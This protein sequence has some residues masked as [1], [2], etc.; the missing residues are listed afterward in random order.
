MIKWWKNRCRNVDSGNEADS[1]LRDDPKVSFN[2]EPIIAYLNDPDYNNSALNGNEWVLNE[3]TNFD[4]SL[5]CDDV[6]GLVDMSPLH[7]P[8]P[9]SMTCMHIEKNDGSVFVVP[10]SK[11]DQSPIIFGKV[12]YWITTANDSNEN[13]ELP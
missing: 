3:K 6:N 12:Q 4:Y 13:L 11:K 5:Y 9:M 2:E 8:L 7:M 1:E 10:P